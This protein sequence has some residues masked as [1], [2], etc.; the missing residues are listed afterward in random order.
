M[1]I[2]GLQKTT[3]LDYP[4]HVAATVF[5]GGC[6]MRCPFC[7]NWELVEHPQSLYTKKS[8]FQFLEKRKGI[9][10]GI[11]ISGGEPTIHPKLPDF[12]EDIKALG[13]LIKLDTNGTNP[14]M[15]RQLIDAGKI[16][17]VAMDIKSGCSSYSSCCGCDIPMDSIL[18]SIALLKE[19]PI[20]YEFRTTVVSE[21]HSEEDMLEIGNMI[22]G[23]SKYFLQSFV[24][25]EQ[26]PTENF[27]APSM[28]TLM[29]YQR[30]L[31]PFVPD[32]FIRGQE[33]I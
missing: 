32:T 11:C 12:I 31:K 10:D 13:Y 19:H 8:F 17:Y 2:A 3:L 1:N 25:S 9:L 26:V 16:D 29:G 6:N 7:H 23:A 15:L 28:E 27:H 4:E 33:S 21:L 5:L 20:P 24:A 14:A 30:L 22:Q 18:E